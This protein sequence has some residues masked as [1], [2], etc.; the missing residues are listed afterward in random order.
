[1]VELTDAVA[2][3]PSAGGWDDALDRVTS[4]IEPEGDIHASAEYRGHLARV[5]TARALDAA[6]RDSARRVAA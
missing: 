2:G 5:L 1:V 6:A 3:R 4:A